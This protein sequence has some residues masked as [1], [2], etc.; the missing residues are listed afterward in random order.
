[1]IMFATHGMTGWRKIAFG[2]VADKMMK[3]AECPVLVCLRKQ[4]RMQ[5]ITFKRLRPR[6]PADL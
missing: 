2:S 5:R 6:P 4:Q 3:E 1:M